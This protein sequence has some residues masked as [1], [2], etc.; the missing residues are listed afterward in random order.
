[1]CARCGDA[2]VECKPAALIVE[3]RLARRFSAKAARLAPVCVAHDGDV[4]EALGGA[5]QIRHL[6]AVPECLGCHEH[7]VCLGTSP[8]ARD[9]FG[10]LA[11]ART[12]ARTMR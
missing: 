12:R 5:P 9:G 2:T 8:R 10:E 1:M 11:Q 3:E 6:P 7:D 4:G